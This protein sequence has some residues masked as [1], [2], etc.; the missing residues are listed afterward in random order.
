MIPSTK[1]MKNWKYKI[2]SSAGTWQSKKIKSGIL[3]SGI[4]NSKYL[5]FK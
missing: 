3:H 5:Y 2:V 1:Y 4:L